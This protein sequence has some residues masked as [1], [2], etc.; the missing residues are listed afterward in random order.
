MLFATEAGAVTFRMDAAV[1]V[2]RAAAVATPPSG[3][4]LVP[5][6]VEDVAAGTEFTLAAGDSVLFPPGIS[7]EIRIEGGEAAA[8]DL[9]HPVAR[10]PGHAGDL[11]GRLAPGQQPHDPPVAALHRIPGPAVAAL[12]LGDGA[13]LRDD[14]AACHSPSLHP[15]FI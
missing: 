12:E 15:K 14:Q 9:A 13:I 2:N 3:A 8:G 6:G 1:R 4:E 11:G 7:G 5:P 10:V